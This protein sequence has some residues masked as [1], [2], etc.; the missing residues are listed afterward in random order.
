MHRLDPTYLDTKYLNT[1]LSTYSYVRSNTLGHCCAISQSAEILVKRKLFSKMSRGIAS[2]L[3]LII[4]IQQIFCQNDFQNQV[5]ERLGKLESENTKLNEENTKL[6]QKLEFFKIKSE[7]RSNE[8]QLLK[9]EFRDYKQNT[10]QKIVT[11]EQKFKEQNEDLT[12]LSSNVNNLQEI[13][14]SHTTAKACWQLAL[15]VSTYCQV[16]TKG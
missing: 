14:V 6:V 15:Q 11:C 13:S 12:T 16:K 9:N 3:I 1:L 2:F 8:V 5:L 7:E 4:S 10:D